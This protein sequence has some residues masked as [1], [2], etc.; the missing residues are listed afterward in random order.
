MVSTSTRIGTVCASGKERKI[1]YAEEE[2]NT[3]GSALSHCRPAEGPGGQGHL[4]HV[5]GAERIFRE[6]RVD[7][8]R[9]VCA[10]RVRPGP[11][12]QCTRVCVR[13]GRLHCDAGEGR[14]RSHTD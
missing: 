11:S 14:T 5:P 10:R 4:A 9:G 2:N 1:N 7:D 6:G 3:G 8:N 13:A 12:T